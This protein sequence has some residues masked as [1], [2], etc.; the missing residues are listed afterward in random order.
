MVTRAGRYKKTDHL[1]KVAAGEIGGVKARRVL[2]LSQIDELPHP[3]TNLRANLLQL[4][5]ISDRRVKLTKL[6]QRVEPHLCRAV[7]SQ[8]ENGVEKGPALQT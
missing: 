4:L 7:A 8:L 6:F 1:A 5:N 2:A 3:L